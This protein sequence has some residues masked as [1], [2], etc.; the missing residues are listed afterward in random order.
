LEDKN[1][2]IIDRTDRQKSKIGSRLS[3]G[4]KE[5]APNLGWLA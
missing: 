1:K 5:Q 4:L 2:Q 3:K